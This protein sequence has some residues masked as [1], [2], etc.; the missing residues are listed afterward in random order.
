MRFK[1]QVN[2][3]RQSKKVVL[4]IVEGITD[5]TSLGLVLSKLMSE[6]QVIRFKVI[7]GDLTAEYGVTSSNCIAKLV[8]KVKE[9]LASD[10]YKKGDLQQIIHLVDLDGVYIKDQQIIKNDKKSEGR[11]GTYYTNDS[12]VTDNMEHM[13]NR[14]HQKS[15][16]LNKLTETKKIYGGIPYSI[17]FFSCNLEH[18]LYDEQNFADKQKFQYAKHTQDLYAKNPEKFI[19]FMNQKEIVIDGVYDDTWEYIKHGNNSL[20]RHSNFHLFLNH[21]Q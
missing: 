8:G 7:G 13:K 5:E 11:T 16:I 21:Y 15:D 1:R 6:K 20:K 12:I 3:L 4:F 17:Y 10:F 14:N 2:L 9:F 19:E 18:V